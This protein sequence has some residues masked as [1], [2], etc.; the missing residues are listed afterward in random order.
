MVNCVSF[1][2]KLFLLM[3]KVKLETILPQLEGEESP[4]IIVCPGGAGGATRSIDYLIEKGIAGE[5]LFILENG[6]GGWP[7][8]E[9]LAK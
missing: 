8:D 4:I 7:H 9:L 5:R 3:K 6:Q 1:Y 2:Q